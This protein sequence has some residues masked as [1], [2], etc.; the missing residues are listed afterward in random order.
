MTWIGFAPAEGDV[1]VTGTDGFWTP[2][3]TFT[4]TGAQTLTQNSGAV[5]ASGMVTINKPSGTVTLSDALALNNTNQDLNLTSGT[6]NLN[7]N[8]LT[9]NRNF[10]VSAGVTLQ[11]QGGETITAGSKSI[12]PDARFTFT[13]N[14]DGNPDTSSRLNLILRVCSTLQNPVFD[15]LLSDAG[16][17]PLR[18][19]LVLRANV[20][21]VVP[22]DVPEYRPDDGRLVVGSQPEESLG[23]N[24]SHLI[25]LF[26][27]PVSCLS[28]SPHWAMIRLA[29]WL[30]L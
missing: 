16:R 27:E 8:N 21:S 30:G 24:A 20:P 9:V 28:R 13:G 26:H 6:L 18:P 22:L 12:D 4:G 1:S 14:G 10:T 25:H 2:A 23:E 7:G 29:N 15:R 19:H 3:L 17:L 11:L 5:F